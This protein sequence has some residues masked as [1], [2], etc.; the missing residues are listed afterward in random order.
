MLLRHGFSVGDVDDCGNTALHL[1]SAGGFTD[2]VKTLLSAGVD[3]T[4]VNFYGNSALDL[5]T[6]SD[7]R[8][9]LQRLAGQHRCAATNLG[10]APHC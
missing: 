8:H 2:I 3:L 6:N 4:V 10:T 7:T 9:L 1:A 5:A